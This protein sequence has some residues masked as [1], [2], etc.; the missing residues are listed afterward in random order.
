MNFS[1]PH[2][3]QFIIKLGF[4]LLALF[5]FQ[6]IVAQSSP[7]FTSPS[8]AYDVSTAKI[9]ASESYN[10]GANETNG[11]GLAFNNDGSKMFVVGRNSDTVYEYVLSTAYNPSTAVYSTEFFVG[12]EEANPGEV[13]FNPSGTKMFITGASSDMV[14]EYNLAIPFD[15]S[16]STHTI[17]D[18]FN[19]LPLVGFS[20]AVSFNDMGTKMFVLDLATTSVFEFNLGVAY[21][22]STAVYT[23][24]SFNIGGEHSNPQGICFSAEGTKMYIIGSG[25]SSLGNADD[26]IVEYGLGTGFDVDTAV[27]AGDSEELKVGAQDG[28]PMDVVFDSTGNYLFVLGYNWNNVH[29]YVL[30]ISIQFEENNAAVVADIEAN[31]GDGGTSDSGITY[32]LAS[33]GDNDFFNL[34]TST[35]ELT[36]V[37]PPDYET[38]IDANTDNSYNI[39]VTA[40]DGDGSTQLDII[41]EVTNL[42]ETNPTL[43]L[44]GDF[45]KATDS[46]NCFYTVQGTEFNPSTATDDSG[47]LASL[48]YSLQKMTPNP[49]LIEENFDT[50][51]WDANNFEL[52]T[53]TGSVVNG[54][55]KSDTSSRGTLRTTAEFVPTLAN[56]LYVSATLSYTGGEGIAFVGT[57]STGEQPSG[58]FNS[59]PQG[60]N[61]RIH[62]F[63]DGQTSTA[64]GYDLQPRPGNAFYTN[65]VRFEI[66]DDGASMSVTMTNL[67][68]GDSYSFSYNTNYTSGSNRVVFSGDYSVSWDDIQISIGAHEYI[69]EYQNGS[70]SVAGITLEPGENIIVWSAE[71]AAGNAVSKSQVITVEDTIDP[72]VVTQNMTITLDNNGEASIIPSEINNNSTDNCGIDTLTLNKQNFTATDTGDNT[73]TLT[74]TDINGNSHSETAIVTVINTDVNNDGLHD[75]AFVTT[76]KTDNPGNSN[77]TSITIPTIGT[78]YSY[79]VDWENDGIF[80]DFGV[81]GDITHDYGIAGTYTVVIK[82]DFPRIYFYWN[83]GARDNLKILSI[84]QWGKIKWTSMQFSFTDCSNLT[85]VNATD[86][87]DFS[88]VSNMNSMF[89]GATSF[90]G[91]IGN[92]DV[93]NVTTMNQMFYRASAFNQ[94]IGDWNV[95]NV[96]I[97]DNIFN[98]ATSFN[99]DIGNWDVRNVTTMS[100]M[101]DGATSFNQD[102]GS[103]KVSNVWG[104]NWMFRSAT[105]FNQDISSWEVGNVQSMSSMFDNA[106]AFN[107]NI[108]SWD[109]G[110]VT[111]MSYMFKGATSFNQDIGSWDVSNVTNMKEMFN[112]A[113]SFDQ[114]VGSWDLSS[115]REDSFD[116]PMENM[117]TGVTLSLENYDGL[118]SGW[119]TL[120]VGETQIPANIIFDAGSS[121]YCY[122]EAGRNILT[123]A[124]YNWTIADNGKDCTAYDQDLDGILDNV[125][126]C[127]TTSNADQADNDVDG[128]GDVCDTDDDNDGTPDAEDAFPLD[129]T[130]DTDTDNDGTGDNAD[131]DD[132]NDGTPD[133]EDA[134]P[135]DPTEDTDTDND[136]TGDNADTDDDNDGT[137]DAEDAFPLDPTEDTDTDNDG[138]GDNADTDDDNDGTPDAE[139][140]F[141]L[142]P[143]EDTDTDNDGTGD[144]ADTDDDNDGTP[145]T[146]D[147][148]PL[149]PTEDTDTDNDGTGD[150]ADTDDDNDGTPDADD[151][152]PLDSTEDT[153]TDNDGTGDNADTDDDNDGTLDTEDAFP[154][155]PT[156]DTDTDNDG[157]GDN[158]DLDDDG[159][160]QSDEDETD[161]GSDPLDASSISADA[162][163]DSIPDCV[164]GD[165]EIEDNDSDIE[166]EGTIVYAQAFTPNGDNIN[167]TWIIQGIEKFPSAVVTVFNR[168]GNEVFKATN[169]NNN[170]DGRRRSNSEKLPPGSYYFV[171][172][173]HNGKAPVNGWLFLN[174]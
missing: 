104:M 36:F 11:Y 148:L 101:F 150:N 132:D 158:A 23:N 50:G 34:N 41:I 24:K 92:W 112:G 161:C 59:E 156:E 165:F 129:P 80:D 87:P 122:G 22:V 33:G 169:Y 61:L 121:V 118:L 60:L 163:N 5:G 134:F 90:N 88:L 97:M 35:G 119:S 109:V 71:D 81:T 77:A 172:D 85:S 26:A 155:D 52:G 100:S 147:A 164:D 170:W 75:E 173:L 55:Y 49:N 174:Y 162:D 153:D 4:L 53:N 14:I 57:R 99:Q 82:G 105:S 127:P 98:S 10:F 15:V 45:T 133:A 136:G 151:A 143:T 86:I 2:L 43:V 64:T 18:D 117:F 96:T 123:T 107:Q 108:G 103:W 128:E 68:T 63:N 56:P 115:I 154:L 16:T 25:N 65:P 72:V 149:D 42:D 21:D 29:K 146:E 74:V 39:T 93:S 48:T 140:A 145:D 139:D 79:D 30:Q 19:L 168:Y 95:G 124:P 6:I 160:G 7:V 116:Q 28:Q 13:I 126:N 44:T 51:S 113:S 70:N 32:S 1:F 144:N 130:E 125:D 27:Y 31:D 171:I 94:D 84:E 46:D 137:P 138:T 131:T 40:T 3:N 66:I 20:K 166:E 37:S 152:F 135:L 9:I 67:V 120:E 106:I 89:D 62:N 110:T 76:W 73:V 91:V 54:T 58:Q 102:I 114:N 157:T 111:N 142:D 141:P 17:G 78:G 12:T 47:S 83:I 8:S 38:P 167:D 159:D 69:Q